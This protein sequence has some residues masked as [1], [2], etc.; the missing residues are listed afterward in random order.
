MKKISK[1]LLY[2]L[3]TAF[4][5]QA[6]VAVYAEVSGGTTETTSTETDQDPVTESDIV[7]SQTVLDQ[8]QSSDP[9]HYDKNVAYYKHLLISLNVHDSFKEEIERLIMEGYPLQAILIGYEFLYESFGLITELAPMIS[10]KTAETKWETIFAAY[11]TNHPTFI[12]RTFDSKGL[13]KLMNNPSLSSDD[14]MIADRVS[15]VTGTP[16]ED[17]ITAKLGVLHWKSIAASKGVLYS[18]DKLPTVPIT[19]EQINKYTGQNGMT[20]DQVVEAFVLAFKAGKDAKIVMD[21]LI[22]GDSKEAIMADS[23]MEKYE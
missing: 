21:R 2:L 5:F 16:F 8:I 12:P 4:I 23:Y 17:L 22:A 18:A 20:E 15:F 11:H 1:M 13:D 7:I 14:I 10:L 19:I 3:I 6:G 9:E